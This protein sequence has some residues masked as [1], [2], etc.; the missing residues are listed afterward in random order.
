MP[1][2]LT[3]DYMLGIESID[4]QHFKLI[5]IINRLSES[6]SSGKSHGD[7]FSI[8]QE[9]MQ[10]AEKHFAYEEAYFVKC[11]YDETVPHEQEHRMFIE[12]VQNFRDRS[13]ETDG[14]LV[15]VELLGFLEGWLLHHILVSD[16]HYVEKFRECGIQ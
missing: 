12:D 5:D 3:E 10:Y 1:I 16:K 9:L 6:I 4:Q 7:V 2:T 8:I 11:G 13:Q 15:A 14:N